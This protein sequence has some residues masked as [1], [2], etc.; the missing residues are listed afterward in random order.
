MKKRTLSS[1]KTADGLLKNGPVQRF[2]QAPSAK[3]DNVLGRRP[4]KADPMGEQA[5]TLPAEQDQNP[6]T[7]RDPDLRRPEDQVTN[8]DVNDRPV[9]CM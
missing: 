1:K 4:S 7:E 2:A 9:D 5:G 6:K 3:R 8:T